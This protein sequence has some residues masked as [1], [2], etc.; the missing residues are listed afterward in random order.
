MIGKLV[1]RLREERG[2]SL[3]RMETETGYSRATLSLIENGKRK[4]TLEWIS[5]YSKSLGFTMQISDLS[6]TF[7]PNQQ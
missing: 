1:K 5:E 6:I 3:K 2:L 7:V 4:P